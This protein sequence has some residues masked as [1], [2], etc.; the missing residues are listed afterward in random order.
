MT[1]LSPEVLAH[2]HALGLT[3][4]STGGGADYPGCILPDGRHVIVT[5]PSGERAP[6]HLS[7]PAL[8]YV[9]DSAFEYVDLILG[10]LPDRGPRIS[11][12]ALT[13]QTAIV[14]AAAIALDGGAR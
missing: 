8:V 10:Q 11:S 9:Y 2:A 4:I 5:D 14:M 13:T 6:A 7:A 12:Y 1:T 3:T